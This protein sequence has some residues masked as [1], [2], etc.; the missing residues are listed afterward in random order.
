MKNVRGVRGRESVGHT[1]HQVH[2]LSPRGALGVS[3]V[4]QGATVHEL[5]DE[6]LAALELA[7][8]VDGENVRMIERGGHPRLTLEALARGRIGDRLEQKLYRD[9]AI[10]LR[11]VGLV[12][13]THSSFAEK[14]ID[15]VGADLRTFGQR[16]TSGAIGAWVGRLGEHAEG[17]IM[18]E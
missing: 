3:P 6:E 7:S 8:V 18:Q 2:G 11:V 16:G 17:H 12:N 14:P 1:R 4:L 10:E 13:L 5:G 9:R 15:S